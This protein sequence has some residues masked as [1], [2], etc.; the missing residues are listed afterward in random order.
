[1]RRLQRVEPRFVATAPNQ[2]Q[3][4][5]FTAIWAAE[6]WFYVAAVIDLL[7]RRV[8]GWSMSPTMATQLVAVPDGSSSI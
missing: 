4:A 2:M 8:G 1:M 7:L 3:I 5:D 6:G